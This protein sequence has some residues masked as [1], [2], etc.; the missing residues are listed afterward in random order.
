MR[1]R[2]KVWTIRPACTCASLL[3][4]RIHRERRPRHQR[5]D[6]QELPS[7]GERPSQRSKETYSV[8]GKQ[9]DHAGG[10]NM[11]YIKRRRTLLCAGVPGI[12][13]QSLQHHTGRT[14]KT[15]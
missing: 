4:P 15:A 6:V 7:C 2:Q 11:S 13:R 10:K 3:H 14:E 1:M 9:L 8:E 12:L 5:G